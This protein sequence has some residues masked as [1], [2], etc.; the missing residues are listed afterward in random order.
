MEEEPAPTKTNWLVNILVGIAFIIAIFT[1][2]LLIFERDTATKILC[3]FILGLIVGLIG[4]I[5]N[6]IKKLFSNNTE[7]EKKTSD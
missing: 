1:I 3:H 5:I 7:D 2:T 4:F 6:Y